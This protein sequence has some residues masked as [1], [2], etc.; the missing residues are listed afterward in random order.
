MP[1]TFQMPASA[2]NSFFDEPIIVEGRRLANLSSNPGPA[3]ARNVSG[4]FKA[5]VFDDG[6]VDLAADSVASSDEKAFTLR[7]RKADWTYEF[8]PWRG[9][10]I[11][12]PERAFHQNLK[13]VDVEEDADDFI[14]FAK[15]KGSGRD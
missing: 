5:C 13:A 3:G 14:I 9:M 10:G 11:T 7:I 2:F 4:R 12:L 15:S 6:A 1:G 8:P